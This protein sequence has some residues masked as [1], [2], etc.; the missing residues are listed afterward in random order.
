MREIWMVF[1]DIGKY[2]YFSLNAHERNPTYK[3]LH[4]NP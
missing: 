1:R 2:K 3:T 4:R